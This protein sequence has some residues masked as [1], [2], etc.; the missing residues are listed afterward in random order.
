MVKKSQI[1]YYKKLPSNLN[2]FIFCDP[3]VSQESYSDYTAFVVVAIDP[4][5]SWY[6]VEATQ[7]KFTVSQ[8]IDKMF[9]LHGKYQPSAMG[10]EVIGLGQTLMAAINSE[11]TRRQTYLPLTP[12]K[13]QQGTKE[14]RI[15]STIQPKFERGSVLLRRGLDELEDQLLT[16]PN[17]KHDDIIDA[18]S[19]QV[20]FW[21]KSCETYR[22]ETQ[23]EAVTDPFAG[24]EVIRELLE[25]GSLV[26]T[27]PYD[28][29]LMSER[30][31]DLLPRNDYV[32]V[33]TEFVL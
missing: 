32:Y 14:V 22:T 11:E 17:S 15:R 12:I 13:S 1:K 4:E 30:V 16:F 18:L 24:E 29:G 21:S 25:R 31:A 5:E 19:M 6:V 3:A 9:F 10:I 8:M 28:I 33:D 7:D 26:H 20:D 27:Y 23:T 2:Y